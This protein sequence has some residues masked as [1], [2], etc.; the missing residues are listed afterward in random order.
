MYVCM[1]YVCMYDVCMYVCMYV[2]MYAFMHVCVYVCMYVY[3]CVCV[4]ACEDVCICICT[5]VHVCVCVCAQHC[6]HAFPKLRALHMPAKSW[7]P[8]PTPARGRQGG[9]HQQATSWA[10]SARSSCLPS[11]HNAV[12][13]CCSVAR[14][15]F[16]DRVGFPGTTRM[17]FA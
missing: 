3:A 9:F 16:D 1:M 11:R 6:Q 7:A 13:C 17:S 5:S 2:Y 12:A 10:R 15:S 14:C 8:R 4:C